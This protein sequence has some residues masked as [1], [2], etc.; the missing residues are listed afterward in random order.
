M[1][2]K[3][4]HMTYD[5]SHYEQPE[6]EYLSQ[7]PCDCR[8]AAPCSQCDGKGYLEEWVPLDRVFRFRP[9]TIVGYRIA[10]VPTSCRL[11]V[12][13]EYAAASQ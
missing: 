11:Y 1:L 7:W 12:D 13:P 9:V 5:L 10:G 6:Y 2:S 8:K 4:R 3:K